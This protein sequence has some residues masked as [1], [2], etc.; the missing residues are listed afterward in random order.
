MHFAV[1][2]LITDMIGGIGE[3]LSLQGKCTVFWVGVAVFAP[4]GDVEEVAGV[5]LYAGLVT[6]HL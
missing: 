5:E 6:V 3:V 4:G 1:L 2:T